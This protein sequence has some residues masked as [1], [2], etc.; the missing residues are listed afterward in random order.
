MHII[1]KDITRFHAIYWPAF[2]MSAGIE[3]PKRV[4][5]HGW[6]LNRGEKISKSVGN[7]IDPFALVDGY[8]LDPVRY[9]FLREVPFGQDGNYSHEAIVT[10]INADLANNLG[11]LAQRSLTM[12]AKNLGG[13]V[14]VTHGF[15]AEDEAFLAKVDALLPA[16]REAMKDFQIHRFLEGVWAVLAEGN[17]YFDAAEPWKLRKSDPARMETVLYTT[18]EAVR[19]VAILIQPV[20]PASA[21]K[22]LDLLG[23]AADK[24]DFAA[25]GAGGRLGQRRTVA[26]TIAGISTVCGEGLKKA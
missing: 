5:G 14:P 23:V 15:T 12:I 13:K 17:R 7:V 24:R 22:L 6:L 19:Q 21:G 3:L 16:A 18:I 8:G 9:F 20:M 26:G 11:N 2:L 25:L 1:G 4:Y 10:R